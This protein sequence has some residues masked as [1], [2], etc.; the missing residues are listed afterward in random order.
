MNG[1]ATLK[2]PITNGNTNDPEPLTSYG[3]VLSVKDVC[4]ITGWCRRVVC[5]YLASGKIPGVKVGSR[6]AV[7]KQKLIECLGM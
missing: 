7:P 4:E 2:P 1:T 3:E 6:W 5:A